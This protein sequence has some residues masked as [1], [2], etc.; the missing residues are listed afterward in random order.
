MRFTDC[1]ASSATRRPARVDPVSD[2]MATSG[3]TVS[4]SPTTGPVPV[5]RLKTP[6]GSPAASTISA[7]MKALSGA[8]SL[9]LT[10]TVQPAASAGPTLATIWCRG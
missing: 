7:R 10:T 2:T 4:R 8:T 6:G 3:W 1:E 9:G 5:T